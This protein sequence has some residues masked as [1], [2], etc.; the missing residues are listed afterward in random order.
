MFDH[1]VMFTVDERV[2]T[3]APRPIWL[4]RVCCV[5]VGCVDALPKFH[6]HKLDG[7]VN[8]RE[9]EMRGGGHPKIKTTTRDDKE[10][11]ICY[12]AAREAWVYTVCTWH[13]SERLCASVHAVRIRIEI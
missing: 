7:R 1:F 11:N 4:G 10:L 13:H 12:G 8:E 3:R 6:K 2:L 9:R 5:C